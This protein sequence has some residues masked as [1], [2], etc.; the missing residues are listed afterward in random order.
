MTEIEIL[1]NNYPLD[2]QLQIWGWEVAVFLFLGG[3][4][5]GLM[6]FSTLLARRVPSHQR[7]RWG[8]RLPFGA[9][10]VLTLGIVALVL[11]LEH[12]DHVMRFYAAL[13]VASPISWSAWILLLLYP[14]T[15]LFGLAEMTDAEE[16]RL[17][18]FAPFR[19][20]RMGGLIDS[21]RSW[22][23]DIARPLRWINLL[24][25]IALGVCTG[26][27]LGTLGARPAWSSAI[28]G[29]LFL[30]SGVSTGAALS[31]LLPVTEREH[32]L[33]RRWNAAAVGVELVLLGLFL[34]G[35][36]TGGHG[37][38][39]AAELFLGGRYTASF[40]SLVVLAGMVIP[41]LIEALET[42]R[43][44]PHSFAAPVLLLAGGVSLRWILVVAGQ[45]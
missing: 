30:V 14:V 18:G 15:V 44:A 25:G 21:A 34:A 31:M 17:S 3:L 38:R 10:I 43:G 13:M 35:L 9:P 40:W 19:W 22:A 28:L 7:S 20:L 16:L 42:L 12:R 26:V 41:L 11:D 5:A 29:P 33:L 1:R 32:R 39:E 45:V 27:L 24:L 37:A 23:V 6:I 2:P 4:A 36:A 8:R